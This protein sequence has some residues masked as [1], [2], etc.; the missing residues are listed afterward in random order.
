LVIALLVICFARSAHPRRAGGTEL[1]FN[2]LIVLKNHEFAFC[3]LRFSLISILARFFRNRRRY[4]IWSF[5]IVGCLS[6]APSNVISNTVVFQCSMQ[7][8][9]YVLRYRASLNRLYALYNRK[10]RGLAQDGTSL[11][12][13]EMNMKLS[14]PRLFGPA[15]KQ[16]LYMVDSQERAE[17]QHGSVTMHNVANRGGTGDNEI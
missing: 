16:V 11:L 13:A 8:M 5:G 9:S 15:C 7:I 3:G 10:N 14:L 1:P 2:T 6:G 4:S 17:I 12:F